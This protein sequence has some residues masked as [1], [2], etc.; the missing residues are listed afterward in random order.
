MKEIWKAVSGYE[1]LYEVSNLGRV[2]SHYKTGRTLNGPHYMRP[3]DVRGY[4]QLVFCKN[5]EKR[6]RLVHRLVAEAFLGAPPTPEHQ[7]N[8]K[9]MNK[10][11]NVPANLEWVTHVAN[12]LHAAAVIPR[13]R[14]EANHSKLTESEVRAMRRAHAL[15]G[16]TL[17]EL[18]RIYGVSSVTAHKII[19][20]EKWK[21]VA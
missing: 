14:G 4:K 17:N 9:D 7:V 21:H 3:G 15:G 20:R 13:N 16:V 5:G 6:V 18:G 19:R 11:N 1:G 8:H 12:I 10:A 2:R